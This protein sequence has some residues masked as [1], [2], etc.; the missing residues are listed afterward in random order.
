MA[1]TTPTTRLSSSFD[2]TDVEAVEVTRGPQGTLLG[3]NT[4]VGVVNVTTRRPIFTP[5]ASW[6]LT[7]GQHGHRTGRVAAGGPII[8]D[9]L[10][11]RANLR[12]AKAKATSQNAYNRDITYT[13]KDRVSGRLQFLLTPD[14]SFSARIALDAQPRASETTNGRTINLPTPKL[15]SNGAVNPLS[16]DTSTRLARRW[17]TQQTGYSYQDNFLNE[18]NGQVNNDNQRPLVTGS[19]G[20]AAELNW[21]LDKFNLTSITAYKDYH[22]NAT[23][24]EGTPFDVHRNSGGFWNDYRQASAGTASELTARAVSSITRPGS[25]TW[26]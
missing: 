9:V 25:S 14:A 21:Y 12:S 5:D 15:Y 20:A 7:L 4:S 18:K 17:F 26:T 10:A 24:D 11:Y 8:D 19:N 23:N 13:N 16:T 2:F 6:S 22:F 3:K 1:S